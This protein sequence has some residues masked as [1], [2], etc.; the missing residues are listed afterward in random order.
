MVKLNKDYTKL[1]ED[2]LFFE[3]EKRA[4]FF[5]KK[6][7]CNLGIG[8]ITLAIPE[9][10]TEA[11]C[12][13][14]KELQEEKTLRGYGPSK[15]YLFLREA[16][17]KNEYI[18][19]PITEDEIFVQNGIKNAISSL[20]DL[21]CKTSYVAVCD[22]TYPVYVDS[23]VMAGRE[24]IEYLPCL[25]ENGFL[26]T[27]PQK[28]VD[29][30]YI[31]SP[32]N[33][34]GVA[35]TRKDLKKWVDFAKKQNALIFFD[36]AYEAF[37][38]SD[39][40]PHSIY[41]IPGADE[42]AIEFR[43]FSKSAG[44]TGLRCSYLVLPKKLKTEDGFSIHKFYKRHIDT[45]YG[46][47]SYPI[48]RG[49][50]RCFTED[51]KKALERNLNIYR[52]GAKML[53]EGLISLDYKVFGG[54]H[55]PYIWCKTKNEMSSWDF[56]DLLLKKAQIIAIPGSGFGRCGEGFIRFSAFAN[57]KTIETALNNLEKVTL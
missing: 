36:G 33:P 52:S 55:S 6:S 42:V 23:N 5:V 7:L 14:T 17:Q 50:E 30:I 54:T 28:N 32:N 45:K 18:N 48:Q 27:L 12:S 57:Q 39:D 26:P 34:T 56:F 29:L 53:R 44:F 24:N 9:V 1:N 43:S 31:C 47:T 16:I 20:Q 38:T 19:I 3:I 15:G 4:A 2:Y 13:A 49:A 22:P 40:V 21:F 46:G 10:I 8:D 25:E 37:I 35:F 51:G 41:E 11:I